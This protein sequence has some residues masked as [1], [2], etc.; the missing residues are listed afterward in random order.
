MHPEN[1]KFLSNMIDQFAVSVNEPAEGITSYDIALP[2]GQIVSISTVITHLGPD[3]MEVY[4]A[5]GIDDE[6]IEETRTSTQEK[7]SNPTAKDFI[8]LLRKCSTKIILQETHK[9]HSKFMVRNIP[10]KKTLS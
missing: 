5:A 3:Y 7:K 8:E 2:D 6:T 10:N 4:Y 9:M 1:K